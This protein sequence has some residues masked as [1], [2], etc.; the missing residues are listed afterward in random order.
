MLRLLRWMTLLA[1]TVSAPALAQPA[2]EVLRDLAP[3]GVL[4]AAINFGN[5]VLA[6]RGEDGAPRGVSADLATELAKRLGVA[7]AFVPY[8]AAGKVFEGARTGAWDVGFMAIEPV[9]AAEITF[10]APYVI[11]EGTYMVRQDAAFKEVGDVDR[12]GVRIAVGLGSAYDLYLTRTVQKATVLRARAGGGTAMIEMFLQ[13][14]LDVAAGVR[15]QLDAYAKDHPEMRVMTGYFQEIRQAM[16]MPRVEGLPRAAGAKYLADF[17]EEMKA[18]GF[19]A[20]ALKRSGQVADV[21]P[22]GK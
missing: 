16:G 21:A 20:A 7:V 10:T 11:I 14:Q 13:D 4:R 2:P 17:V 18:S 6:Q 1:V 19:V 22:A 15:Q 3:T 8:E 12:P 5:G 9:R